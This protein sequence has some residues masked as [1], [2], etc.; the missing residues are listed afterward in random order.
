MYFKLIIGK[1]LRTVFN[2]DRDRG[3]RDI[4]CSVSTTTV[5]W[6]QSVLATG[7]VAESKFSLKP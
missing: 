3:R 6:H 2:S 5:V 7:D 1:V 4:E